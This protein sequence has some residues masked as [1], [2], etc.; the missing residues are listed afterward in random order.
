MLK[1]FSEEW[2]RAPRKAALSR[3]LP[4]LSSAARLAA[5]LVALTEPSASTRG[6][7]T[8]GGVHTARSTAAI[9]GTIVIII[10][11]PYCYGE[12]IARHN[13]RSITPAAGAWLLAQG[14]SFGAERR[15][16]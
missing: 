6:T 1:A 10:D 14:H 9:T 15:A 12:R 16:F 11:G 13:I 3:V 7:I 5:L 8:I 2:G 4:G